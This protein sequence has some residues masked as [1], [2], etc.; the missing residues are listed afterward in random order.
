MADDTN[1]NEHEVAERLWDRN[2]DETIF[3][4]KSRLSFFEVC[5]ILYLAPMK[6]VPFD[7]E[8]D[9]N[10]NGEINGGK[11]KQQVSFDAHDDDGNNEHYVTR[12]TILALSK[13][14]GRR[15]RAK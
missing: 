9:D 13:P 1:R 15:T 10:M 14:K 5:T 6:R 8:L 3:I 12:D 2:Y 11:L 7:A 4:C